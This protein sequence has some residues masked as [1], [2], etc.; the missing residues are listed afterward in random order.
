MLF[1]QFPSN[2]VYIIIIAF[3]YMFFGTCLALCGLEIFN[4]LYFPD[5]A[6]SLWAFKAV[7]PRQVLEG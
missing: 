7:H 6:L 1:P 4:L 2:S 5:L 3:I